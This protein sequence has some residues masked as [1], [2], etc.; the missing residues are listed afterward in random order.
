MVGVKS[1]RYYFWTI[2]DWAYLGHRR[3]VE[4]A[5]RHGATIDYRP[6]DLPAI[7]AKTGGILLGQRAQQRQDYRFAELRRWKVRLN[8]PINIEPKF[9]PVAHELSSRLLIAAKLGG[10]PVSEFTFDVMKAAWVEERDISDPN[11]LREIA[12]RHVPEVEQ[13][14]DSAASSEVLAE[15]QRYTDDAPQDGVFGSPFYIFK[16]EPFWGQDR[17]DFLD[18][19]LAR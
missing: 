8:D 5:N 6:V 10:F 3:L 1:I 16:G 14:F 13:L 11:T 2:S 17:L 19:A 9:S 18:E 15:Y 12:A 7:Y 4:I